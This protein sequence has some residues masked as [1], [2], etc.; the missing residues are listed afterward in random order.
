[1]KRGA[2]LIFE[3]GGLTLNLEGYADPGSG[4]FAFSDDD[5]EYI[6]EWDDEDG[7]RWDGWLAK[8][9]ATELAAIR[10]FLN[11]YLPPALSA[12]PADV[13]G[14]EGTSRTPSGGTTAS[15]SDSE[16]KSEGALREKVANLIGSYVV[17]DDHGG[18]DG[19]VLHDV[20]GGD[21]DEATRRVYEL[22]DSVLAALVEPP[23]SSLKEALIVEIAHGRVTGTPA[24]WT[25]NAI[26]K[27]F[28]VATV[29][30][31]QSEEGS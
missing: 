13:V 27:I 30:P 23:K 1:M 12:P 22:T 6:T 17:H 7:K 11:K 9:P 26:I 3:R 2:Q 14:R 10:D 28:D 18:P 16:R 5:L 20:I 4:Q 24:E 29:A 21:Y 25:A 15:K 19:E 31:C 8:L